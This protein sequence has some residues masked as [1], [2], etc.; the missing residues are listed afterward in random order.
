[1]P[2]Y[3]ITGASRGIGLEFVTQLSKDPNN[4]VFG[5]VRNPQTA[6][7]LLEL[8][9][10]RPNVHV[11]KADITDV[12]ALKAAAA[13]V[14]KVTGGSLDYLINNAALLS[15]E[16]IGLT[17]TTYPDEKVLEEDL[18]DSFRTNVVGVVH[19]VNAFLPLLRKGTAKKVITLST[20]LAALDVT[21]GT[22]FAVHVPYSVSKAALNQAVAKYAAE[23]RDEGFV[24]LAI[25][26]GVVDT[27]PKPLTPVEEE[28]FKSMVPKF[29]KYAPHWDG[30]PLS[31]ETFVGLML[32]IIDKVTL[33][34]T[35]AFISHW[36]NQQWL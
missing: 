25:S 19:T 14:G 12:P 23:L 9:K 6:T 7:K 15:N 16:R 32:G 21:L 24:F 31:P 30:Q 10:S 20:G 4:T 11:F 34:D 33:K 26:P 27:V 13:E 8:Q 2:S 29:Q 18:V 1:M 5:L 35:G 3:V 28:F 17:L 22:G 36:G